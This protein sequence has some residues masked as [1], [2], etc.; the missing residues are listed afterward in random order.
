MSVR[1]QVSWLAGRR[2]ASRLP[3][4]SARGISGGGLAA[5]SCGGSRGLGPHPG[6]HRI[7]Y[8][9]RAFTADGAPSGAQNCRR[10]PDLQA[11]IWRRGR[12]P[13]NPVR[14]AHTTVGVSEDRY[15]LS[16]KLTLRTVWGA[17]GLAGRNK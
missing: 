14:S 15:S 7:P 12:M 4:L 6:P 17:R 2:R 16:G 1:R 11:A 10:T 5:Y 3:G 9:P 8:Y 13:S